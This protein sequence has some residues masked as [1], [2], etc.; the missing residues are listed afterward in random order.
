MESNAEA[1]M[2]NEFFST[3]IVSTASLYF[4]LPVAEEGD[5]EAVEPCGVT[6]L[7]AEFRHAVFR[8]AAACSRIGT[9][10]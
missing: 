7:T 5:G 6:I 8:I 2:A 3:G 9:T 1:A 4:S 10:S